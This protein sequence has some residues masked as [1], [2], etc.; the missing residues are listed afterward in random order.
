MHSRK[1]PKS[2]VAA[3]TV[4]SV[5]FVVTIFLAV[6]FIS[7]SFG[8]SEIDDGRLDEYMIFDEGMC[9]YALNMSNEDDNQVS[10]TDGF[11][12]STRQ[13]A[14]D[15]REEFADRKTEEFLDALWDLPRDHVFTFDL[16]FEIIGFPDSR[17]AFAVYMDADFT[18]RIFTEWEVENN[19]TDS[20]IARGT[21]RLHIGP[22]IEAAGRVWGQVYDYDTFETITLEESGEQFLHET[23]RHESWGFLRQYFLV[24]RVDSYGNELR[25]PQVT[26]FT[27]ENQ[28]EAPQSEFFITDDGFGGF[29]WNPVEG[30]EYYLVVEVPVEM[31]DSSVINPVAKVTGTSWVNPDTSRAWRN[32]MNT[33]FRGWSDRNFSV[34]AVNSQ[35]HSALGNI[36]DGDE[37]RARLPQRWDLWSET[38][39]LGIVD[40]NYHIFYPH[41]GLIPTHLTI[42]MVDGARVQRRLIFD[43]ERLVIKDIDSFYHLRNPD[44]EILKTYRTFVSVR[45]PFTVEGTIFR[46]FIAADIN[47]DMDYMG[48]IEVFRKRA[49]NAAPRGGAIIVDIF[50][51][52][53]EDDDDAMPP[54]D[55]PDTSPEILFI[56]SDRVYANSPLSAFLARNLMVAN[57]KIDLTY[58][59]ESADWDYLMDAFFEA[60][61]QNP[62]ILHV[63][64]FMSR[65]GSNI[66][67]VRYRESAETIMRQQDA[68]RQIVPEII[69]EI[70][71][72]GMSDLEKSVAI[73]RFL[74]D[75]A[76]YDWEALE[77]AERN[78]FRSV[79]ARFNDTFTAYGIL[80]NRV[81]VC[82]G[83][84]AAYKLLADEAG[85][86]AIVVT[87][88]LDG[89]LPH[90][91]NRV[92]ID[93]HWH[94]LDVTNN[95]NE[96]LPNVLLHLPDSA[97]VGILV[98][99]SKF[100][101]DNYLMYYRSNDVSGEYFRLNNRYY[102]LGDISQ[103]I[104]RDI[105][106]NGYAI[107]RTDFDLCDFELGMIAENVMVILNIDSIA[108]M[109]WLGLI[110]M[111]DSVQ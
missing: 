23:G 97:V 59:P 80:I 39:A 64:S 21:S 94:I 86:R 55:V 78:N 61:Y 46:G 101:L 49:E 51:Y 74:I 71:T 37:I 57:E 11:F 100:M 32:Q 53:E 27:I 68:I 88:F 60:M 10:Q 70:I 14:H 4:F 8:D 1:I 105:R 63:D 15:L 41:V 44:G 48:D 13:L 40:G 90:A 87:G 43:F 47:R 106:A 69:A 12:I 81:G 95:A 73:N 79:D 22:G 67:R 82:S 33:A 72:P 3:I 77:D 30:A 89:F 102:A 96:Y 36:H 92:Y 76:E 28:L 107:L 16:N 111:S 54:L 56:P 42:E 83:Y 18:Q 9:G 104:A 66:L 58:F 6:W 17:S 35:T 25:Y 110:W 65:P 31:S 29:R 52:E 50:D 85:L 99:D 84:A 2:A 5:L 20:S 34:I 7:I 62:L 75:T 26:M 109:S 38:K 108:G 19:S 24:V 93:G 103:A 91:W 98:E 45:I